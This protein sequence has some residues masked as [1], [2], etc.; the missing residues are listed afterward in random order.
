MCYDSHSIYCWFLTWHN[1]R[2]SEVIQ[3]WLPLTTDATYASTTVSSFWLFL[4][5]RPFLTYLMMS[6]VGTFGN[7]P[8]ITCNGTRHPFLVFRGN[9]NG[10]FGQLNV[11]CALRVTVYIWGVKKSFVAN[12]VETV[13]LAV[14]AQ[15]TF[16]IY[17][18]YTVLFCLVLLLQ[19]NKFFH[20]VSL[21]H[22]YFLIGSN[23]PPYR[24][25]L[26]IQSL[27]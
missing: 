7:S 19:K 11:R 8:I 16:L 10:W 3:Q 21:F 24:C 9:L 18:F 22:F 4:H 12:W 13:I 2:A 20:F 14:I 27:V 5:F 15:Y 26:L 6:S 23:G 25:F 1:W 17:F